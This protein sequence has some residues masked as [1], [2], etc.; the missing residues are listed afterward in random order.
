MDHLC[1]E[2]FGSLKTSLE[3]KL[4]KVFNLGIARAVFL[5]IYATISLLDILVLAPGNSLHFTIVLTIVSEIKI[6]VQI[7]APQ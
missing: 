3:F 5:K 7:P 6:K 2:G 1:Q 4:R